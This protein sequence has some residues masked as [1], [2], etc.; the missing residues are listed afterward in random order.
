MKMT[1]LSKEQFDNFIEELGGKD[2]TAGRLSIIVD[3]LRKDFSTKN[4]AIT[5]MQEDSKKLNEDYQSSLRVNRDLFKKVGEEVYGVKKEEAKEKS[6]SESITIED[7]EK[8]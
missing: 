6:Y 8:M 2:I 4:E 3:D 5:K 7:L 1:L